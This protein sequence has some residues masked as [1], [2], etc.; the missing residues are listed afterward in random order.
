MSG[1]EN[2][3]EEEEEKL[4]LLHLTVV[5]IVY[6]GMKEGRPSF[7][8]EGTSFFLPFLL[9]LPVQRFVQIVTDLSA[10]NFSCNGV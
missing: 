10:Q 4:F 5:K 8:M 1:P 6:G 7:M 3:E 9:R 2:K